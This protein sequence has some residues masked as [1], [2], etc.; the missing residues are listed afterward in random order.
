IVS[1][2]VQRALE[3]A[4][5]E[6]AWAGATA[7]RALLTGGDVLRR[8][9]ESSFSFKLM[10]NYGP[11]EGTVVATWNEVERGETQ[12][13]PAIG[14]PI[15][16]AQVH[17]LDQ[18]LGA[19][20]AGVT[21]E[22]YLGGAGLARGYLN[23]ADLTA[24]RF[25][26]DPFSGRPGARLYHTGDLGSYLADGRLEFRGRADEQVKIRGYRIEP[27]EI[28]AALSQHPAVR[29]AVVIACQDDSTEKRLIAYI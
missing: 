10:N 4:G 28:E 16:N 20:P 13:E 14:R 24:E 21:G 18:R 19:V 6:E 11:T 27:V 8:T 2:L 26:P 15:H 17:V 5:W 12:R 9:T 22:I 23:R 7:L 1:M 29:E 3:N 25:I